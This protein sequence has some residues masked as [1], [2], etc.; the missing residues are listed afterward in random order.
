M[1]AR[2]IRGVYTEIFVG[3]FFFIAVK[4]S[5]QKTNL[6]STMNTSLFIEIYFSKVFSILLLLIF[7]SSSIVNTVWFVTFS[8][9]LGQTLRTAIELK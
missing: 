6:D 7:F 1:A 8:R 2:L 3:M 4:G 9:S 5:T